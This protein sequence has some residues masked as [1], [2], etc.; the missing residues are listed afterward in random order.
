ML[1]SLHCT[2][3][4]QVVEKNNVLTTSNQIKGTEKQCGVYDFTEKVAFKDLKTQI[5]S[6]F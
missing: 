3:F 6:R 5:V 1:P 2:G 4:Y